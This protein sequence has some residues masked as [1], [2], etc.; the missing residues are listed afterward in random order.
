MTMWVQ[1]ATGGR[2]DLNNPQA[3]QIDIA[4]IAHAL[5]RICRFGGATSRL[6]TVAEHS[7]LCC[8][9]AEVAGMD[10]RTQMA[11]LLHDAPEAYMGDITRP[12]AR[13]IQDITGDDPVWFL[14]TSL[15]AAIGAALGVQ[16]RPEDLEAIEYCD[17]VAL[18]TERKW[19]LH[20]RLDWVPEME[21]LPRSRL[22]LH[23]P[24]EASAAFLWEY[25]R[26]RQKITVRAAPRQKQM[27][28]E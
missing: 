24:A 1:T 14:H 19:L 7:L 23:D 4:D 18:A 16:L 8:S 2:V 13:A 10:V 28:A 26:L 17:N 22:V 15:M 6:Y 27:A 21:P 25:Q 9:I 5:S 11:V 20:P 3:H 12:V